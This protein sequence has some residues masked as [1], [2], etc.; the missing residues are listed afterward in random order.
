[1]INRQKGQL[2]I[3]RSGPIIIGDDS[4]PSL[5]EKKQILEIISEEEDSMSNKY[6]K[7]KH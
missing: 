6:S 2:R 4:K 7:K 1:M 5:D 3:G